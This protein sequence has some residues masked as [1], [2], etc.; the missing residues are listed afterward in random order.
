[1]LC[2]YYFVEVLVNKLLV[3]YEVTTLIMLNNK[4]VLY[5]TMEL[6]ISTHVYKYQ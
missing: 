6:T 1:M 5:L 2:L 4:T 3:G